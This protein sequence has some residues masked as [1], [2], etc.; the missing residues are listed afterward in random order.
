MSELNDLIGLIPAAGKGLRLGLPYPK[1]LYPIIR[2]GRYTPVSQHI[3][4]NL[5]M[6]GADQ[7]ILV[8]NETK[9]QLI[10]YFGDGDHFGRPITY[11]YQNPERRGSGGSAGLSQALDSA[12]HLFR[13]RRVLF[14]MP[15]TIIEP[16]T[17]FVPLKEGLGETVD[18]HLGLFPTTE[19]EQMGMVDH[20]PDGGVRSI[21]DKQPDIGL[22]HCWG[23]VAWGPVFGEYLHARLEAQPGVDFATILNAA[24]AEGL[25]FR[26]TVLAGGSY[27]D[28]GT[29][30]S[31][32]RLERDQHA[33][34]LD[35]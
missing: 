7:L 20:D 3:V 35:A 4:E 28:V 11:V 19:P 5:I 30:E 10:G 16:R 2:D 8:I 17:G 15:D 9:H 18:V 22:Q 27:T 26:A 31:I 29:Y 21:R 13:G 23:I 32:Q 12:Y 34:G 6:A 25:R 14:G 24:L 33:E 1:E